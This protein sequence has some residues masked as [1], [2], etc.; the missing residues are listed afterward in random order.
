[1]LKSKDKIETDSGLNQIFFKS[2][3]TAIDA[4]HIKIIA[5]CLHRPL[6]FFY[7]LV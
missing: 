1:M 6:T 5:H 3:H 2:K 4:I 7:I